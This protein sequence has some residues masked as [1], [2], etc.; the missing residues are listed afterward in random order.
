MRCAAL[1]VLA[2]CTWARRAAGLS[3]PPGR[4]PHLSRT[5]RSRCTRWTCSLAEG[6]SLA[7][8]KLEVFPTGPITS[9]VS[10]TRNAST[11]KLLLRKT[12]GSISVNSP[13]WLID[14]AACGQINL[15]CN[16]QRPVR[17]YIQI[18]RFTT[19]L[20][21]ALTIS[22]SIYSCSARTGVTK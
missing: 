3:R 4:A 10:E 17:L 18:E 2:R 15:S 13:S 20:C 6:A 22:A 12:D 5:F 14:R 16:E 21:L 9:F 1:F 8:T 7:A 11:L 19:C